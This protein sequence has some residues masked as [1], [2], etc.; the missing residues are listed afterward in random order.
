MRKVVSVMLAAALVCGLLVG[1]GKTKGMESS[2]NGKGLNL[3][4]SDVISVNSSKVDVEKEEKL[5]LEDDGW[6]TS[7]KTYNIKNLRRD[8][9]EELKIQY[10][11]EGDS[12]SEIRYSINSDD[13]YGVRAAVESDCEEVYGD[14]VA[15]YTYKYLIGTKTLG[16]FQGDKNEELVIFIGDEKAV[17]IEEREV[18]KRNKL[19]S[20]EE[21][22]N[23]QRAPSKYEI[24]EK[25]KEVLK[26]SNVLSLDI[27]TLNEGGYSVSVQIVVD[28]DGDS[29]LA[30][31]KEIGNKV[32]AF[33]QSYDIIAVSSTSQI[34]ASYDSSGN[35]IIK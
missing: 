10:K 16:I 5:T 8:R 3:L 13:I 33:N 2:K 24:E 21:L 25:A 15:E 31:C 22:Q 27:L 11:F 23:A 1:C 34:I 18:E 12:L 26:D 20:D 6:H 19:I 4:H 29:A 14:T 28:A 17:D 30:K 7:N 32:T 35:E 9:T